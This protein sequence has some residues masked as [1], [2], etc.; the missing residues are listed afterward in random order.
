[1]ERI[2]FTREELENIGVELETDD[3]VHAYI[4]MLGL[5]GMNVSIPELSI[6]AGYINSSEVSDEISIV[7][8]D[9]II[10]ETSHADDDDVE[11]I[12]EMVI[13]VDDEAPKPPP[14]PVAATQEKKPP[15]TPVKKEASWSDNFFD[16]EYL[17]TLRPPSRKLTEIEV[18]FLKNNLPLEDGKS[19]L[20][21][22]CGD[23][24]HAIA[25][26][27]TGAEI[28]GIDTSVPFL[29]QASQVAKELGVNV[30]FLKKDMR[31]FHTKEQFDGV[32]LIGGSF[33]Y[34]SDSEN[35]EIIRLMNRH[36]KTGGKAVIQAVNRDFAVSVLPSRI[37]WEGNGCMV[38]DESYFLQENG[39]VSIKRNT[40]FY[41]GR[42][43]NHKILVRAYTTGELN[44]IV[45]DCGFQVNSVSGSF[46]TPDVFLGPHSPGIVLVLTKTSEC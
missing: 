35:L 14:T 34:F 44:D 4:S 27:S 6:N 9:V 28:T 23:G 7:D 2:L 17:M 41:N 24:R 46:I 16:D 25:L 15:P 31:D 1:M 43:R 19:I 11:D 20:D 33:G 13:Q 26:S 36:L 45:R 8:D 38:M 3:E 18:D 32:Y 30:N 37:W 42:Q 5:T 29:L 40:A 39:C 12:G 10:E 22:G 21:I